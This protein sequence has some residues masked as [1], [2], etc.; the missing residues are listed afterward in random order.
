M[1][2]IESVP[3]CVFP[4][5]TTAIRVRPGDADR[6]QI[7]S[8]SSPGEPAA[9]RYYRLPRLTGTP[10][11]DYGRG[12]I[13]RTRLRSPRLRQSVG[14]VAAGNQNPEFFRPSHPQCQ[15]ARRRAALWP[16]T[17]KRAGGTALHTVCACDG[18]WCGRYWSLN[19]LL[20]RDSRVRRVRSSRIAC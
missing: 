19:P 10:H 18:E 16:A 14:P 20:C 9:H 17:A 8:G 3:R 13:G 4:V 7:G 15:P 5:F 11:S 1:L 2:A 12:L 6:A